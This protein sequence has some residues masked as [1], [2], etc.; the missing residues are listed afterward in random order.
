MGG[1]LLTKCVST[2]TEG[3]R[4][5]AIPPSLGGYVIFLVYMEEALVGL[6]QGALNLSII[7]Y[8]IGIA[9]KAGAV[10]SLGRGV[11]FTKATFS[12][13]KHRASKAVMIK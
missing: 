1:G 2:H 3:V 5:H 4:G 6:N 13:R 8:Q 12:I 7:P 11:H 10:G 9:Y